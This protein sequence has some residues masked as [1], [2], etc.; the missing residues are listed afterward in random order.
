ML[1]YSRDR[2]PTCNQNTECPQTIRPS[3]VTLSSSLLW[4]PGGAVLAARE[5]PGLF[6][7]PWKMKVGVASVLHQDGVR[8]PWNKTLGWLSPARDRA[9]VQPLPLYCLSC[10]LNKKQDLLASSAVSVWPSVCHRRGLVGPGNRPA[11]LGLSSASYTLPSQSRRGP[12]PCPF[13]APR[14]GILIPPQENGMHNS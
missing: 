2:G 5:I 3:P 12:R 9:G 13:T 1:N 11:V 7:S 6:E 10:V 14:S 8:D 4:P